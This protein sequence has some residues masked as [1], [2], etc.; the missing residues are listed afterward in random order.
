MEL[1][2]KREE[3]EY[4]EGFRNIES[5]IGPNCLRRNICEFVLLIYTTE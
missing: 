3:E 1:I 2:G 5:V 4:K